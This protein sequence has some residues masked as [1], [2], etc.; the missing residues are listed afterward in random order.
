MVSLEG[1]DGRKSLYRCQCFTSFVIKH[2][3]LRNPGS[4]WLLNHL[5]GFV[6]R[7]VEKC[8]REDGEHATSSVRGHGTA[9]IHAIAD[10][11]ATDNG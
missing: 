2:F 11:L 9:S 10:E 6:A 1:V 4:V 5:F 8:L 3:Y 7:F